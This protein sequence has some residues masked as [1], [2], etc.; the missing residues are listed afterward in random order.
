MILESIAAWPTAPVAAAPKKAVVM[1]F[2][3]VCVDVVTAVPL[4]LA[5]VV[6]EPYPKD[7]FVKVSSD[8]VPTLLLDATPEEAVL[9]IIELVSE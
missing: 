1:L 4:S 6:P 2:G 9:T 7:T 8:D 5:D 3:I